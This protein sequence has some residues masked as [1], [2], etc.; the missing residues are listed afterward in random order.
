MSCGRTYSW[1]E[2]SPSR[3][4]RSRE[5]GR[6][7]TRSPWR[8]AYRADLV[9]PT[10]VQG[11]GSREDLR[12][13]S[14]PWRQPASSNPWNLAEGRHGVDEGHRDGDVEMESEGKL[15]DEEEREEPPLACGRGRQSVAG[16]EEFPTARGGGRRGHAGDEDSP[17]ARGSG[18]HGVT[19]DEGSPTARGGG[20]R[21]NAG[22]EDS[23][24]AQ[25]GG[26]RGNAGDEDSPTT[27]GGGRR[28]VID[29]K[30][31]PIAWGGGR[32][33]N[34]G[35]EDSPPLRGA[36]E[37]VASPT[38]RDSPL[39][40]AAEG[41]AT[42]A[43]KSRPLRGKKGSRGS[44][45]GMRKSGSAVEKHERKAKKT[46]KES[47]HLPNRA[48]ENSEK[49]A[50][51]WSGNRRRAKEAGQVRGH[52]EDAT[53]GRKGVAKEDATRR[54]ECVHRMIQQQE[55]ETGS[56]ESESSI[57]RSGLLRGESGNG[58]IKEGTREITKSGGGVRARG[59]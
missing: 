29:D 45:R 11:E 28:G 23:P 30:G 43:T 36:A 50:E 34:A 38:T 6:S 15:D 54:R 25:G 46:G 5:R 14:E 17:T 42:P 35:N 10:G 18:R 57:A 37:G 56:K 2:R 12:V 3:M 53:S 52:R 31:S 48:E 49:A 55:K 9:T 16:D 1:R 24:I 26:R 32:R 51:E 8:A 4:R 58:V 39:R 7:P 33:G 19:D 40:G 41:A 47:S 20:R 22:D 44:M 59:K 27:R 21:S 13:R